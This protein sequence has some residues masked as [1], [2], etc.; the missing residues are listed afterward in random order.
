MAQEV[1][2]TAQKHRKDHVDKKKAKVRAGGKFKFFSKRILDPFCAS[3]CTL[4][5]EKSQVLKMKV[6]CKVQGNLGK[7]KTSK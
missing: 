5:R 4:R 2:A 7:M 1:R 3:D 6:L